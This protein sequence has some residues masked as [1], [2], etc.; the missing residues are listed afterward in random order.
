MTTR[1][2]LALVLALALAAA[3]A[4]APKVNDPA[5]VEAVKA[6]MDGYF[7]AASAKDPAAVDVVVADG[8]VL[9]EPN[10]APLAGKEAIGRMHQSFMDQFSI[11]ATGPAVDVRVAGDLAVAYGRYEET[12]TP[13]DSTLAA[14]RASGHWLA[15][16]RRQAGGGWKWEWVMANSDQPLPGTTADGADERALLDIER[17]FAE[18]AKTRDMAFFERVLAKEYT[19]VADGKLVDV[20]AQLAEMK[21]G[22]VEIES[23]TIRDMKVHVAGDAA[24]VW[25]T[26]ESKGAYKGK[27]FN[28]RSK[29]ID[30]FVRRDGRWQ[31]VNSQMTTIKG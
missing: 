10:M 21:A 6:L 23:I 1:F 9:L 3:S 5:D 15:S 2:S 8:T 29:G 12:I 11:D 17:G 27:P 25:M 24:I 30:F 20:A 18:A 4:C 7:K 19:Q 16:L 14:A 31:V 13:K 28:E 26:A 22:R